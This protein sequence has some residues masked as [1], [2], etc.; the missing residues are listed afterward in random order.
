MTPFAKVLNDSKIVP[1]KNG[2][3]ILNG[4]GEKITTVGDYEIITKPRTAAPHKIG[5]TVVICAYHKGRQFAAS[6]KDGRWS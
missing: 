4:S 6:F 1:A 5:D 3:R 2:K